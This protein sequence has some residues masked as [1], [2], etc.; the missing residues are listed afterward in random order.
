MSAP[1][2]GFRKCWPTLA[3]NPTE[4]CVG[5]SAKQSRACSARRSFSAASSQ[6]DSES[7]CFLIRRPQRALQLPRDPARL[8]LL[9]R[10]GLER[11]HV[12]FRPWSEL[13]FLCRHLH[14]PFRRIVSRS[15]IAKAPRQCTRCARPLPWSF[16]GHR[17]YFSIARRHQPFFATMIRASPRASCFKLGNRIWRTTC[18]KQAAKRKRNVKIAKAGAP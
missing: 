10:Q 5:E 9:A 8:R 17:L 18:R 15:S 12:L 6:R 4:C 7:L 14:S 3:H 1:F 16:P 13:H 11:P 2:Q